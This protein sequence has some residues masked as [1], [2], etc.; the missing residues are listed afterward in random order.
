MKRGKPLTSKTPMRKVSAKRK[1]YR[2]SDEGKA[3]LEHMQS[4]KMLP[5]VI[6]NAPPPSDAHH[7]ICRRY[8]NRKAADTEVI[9]L[10]KAHH[11]DGPDAIHNGKL[12]WVAKYGPDYSYLPRVAAMLGEKDD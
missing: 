1:S 6:C 8:G 11:Q 10:C 4:V 7:V 5:C 9:P 12:S 3:G 2:A